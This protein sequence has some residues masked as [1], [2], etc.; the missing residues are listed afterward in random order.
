MARSIR[1]DVFALIGVAVIL[2]GR[3]STAAAGSKEPPASDAA[4]PKNHQPDA[5]NAPASDRPTSF[6]LPGEDPPMP[7]VPLHPR[8]VEDRKRVEALTA[9]SVARALEDQRSWSEAIALLDQ[10]LK[11]D[12]NSVTILRRLSRLCFV[13]GRTDQGID[14]CKHVLEVDPG[15][16]DTITRL[17]TYYNTRKNDVAGAE[18][19]LKDVLAN[20][21]LE[22]KAPGRLI[23][24]F[25]LGKLYAGKLKQV[26]KAADCFA[27]VVEALDDKTANGLSQV[28]HRRILGGDEAAAYQG[29]G[30]AFLLAKRYD[31]AVK[32]FERGLG[33]DAEDPQIPLLLGETLLKTN[34]PEQA[35][36]Q[37]EHFLKRQPQGVEGYELLAKI[38]TALKRENE[39]TPR[40]EEAAR[41]DSK[42]VG[43]QYA[44]A[45]RYRE[46]GQIDRAEAL[47][48]TLLAS[49]PNVQGY[50]A[51][52]ASL[53][54]RRRAE[55][56]LKVIEQAIS[57]PGGLEAVQEPIDG[58]VKDSQLAD[59]VLDA[60]L[61]LLSAVP[62]ALE[63]N[64]VRILTYITTKTGKFDKF[65]PIQQLLLKQ[66][67]SPQ[68]YK[69][70]LSIFF[71]LKKFNVGAALYEEFLAKYPGERNARNLVD[72]AKFLR[73]ADKPEPA[74]AVAREAVKLDPN[75]PESLIQLALVLSSVGKLDEAIDVLAA[76]AKKDPANP[77]LGSI[78]GSLLSQSGRNEEAITL[79]K[80][81]IDKFPNNDE[82]LR[83][84]RSSLSVAYV[85][86]G[87]Y[88]K[89]EAELESLLERNPEEPGVNNDLGYLYAD[90]GKNLEKA[91][92]MIRKALQEDPDRAA[93]LDS[94]GWVLFKRGKFKEAVEPLEMAV[95]QSSE[96]IATDATVFEHL[97]D[98]YFQLQQN[99]KAKSAW[100]SAEKAATKSA[101]SDKRL[102]EIRK[103]LQSLEKLG[104]VPKPSDGKTP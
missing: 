7:F 100:N 97:G 19:I 21:R 52:A 94:L 28:D 41:I 66:N 1:P 43:L 15:D 33:Y 61:K 53:F 6:A 69:E 59:Q 86:L 83:I 79:F 36:A 38:L 98:V 84:A 71:A 91:E 12:P 48:K 22:K 30:E 57:R 76:A 9:F 14:Y 90:Q 103:K 27:K 37:V 63:G 20:P 31:L 54:K 96:D 81:M 62:P 82:V 80:A 11:L 44:L 75:Q 92:V 16:T 89:G 64:G 51:L 88:V 18:A 49:Q 72:L 34:K 26:D 74:V 13:L 24:E 17:V 8:T 67:P 50:G 104:Q 23:A 4:A 56:L 68:S 95:K 93:Y 73:L 2:G 32:S 58:I 35:F 78:L 47:Y 85:N 45:D 3:F 42:N 40:L 46:I 5:P 101:P 65:L 70:A 25:E 55:E 10:A 29:F 77:A 39:I 99:S 60:G 87:D 102:P